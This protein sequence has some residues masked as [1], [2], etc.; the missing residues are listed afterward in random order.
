MYCSSTYLIA[1]LSNDNQSTD[2]LIIHHSLIG[3][4][5]TYNERIF[6]THSQITI[7]RARIPLSLLHPS[8]VR[9]G[10]IG[11]SW[12][13]GGEEPF[14][15]A[16]SEKAS[17]SQGALSPSS[18]VLSCGVTAV[19]K[20]KREKKVK[21]RFRK[22]RKIRWVSSGRMKYSYTSKV[23]IKVQLQCQ[24]QITIVGVGACTKSDKHPEAPL[25]QY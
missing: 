15:T 13:G 17:S 14:Q 2:T 7:S 1:T 22:K 11:W 19:S 10:V 9:V 6:R 23:Q 8:C 24:L 25:V 3:M 5:I 12:V 21:S 4:C 20:G 18:I 16:I